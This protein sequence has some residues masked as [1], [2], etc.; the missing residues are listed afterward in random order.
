MVIN[1]VRDKTGCAVW[2]TTQSSD[3]YKY[4]NEYLKSCPPPPFAESFSWTLLPCFSF[5]G[6]TL[7]TW[8]FH[9]KGFMC[10]S[11]CFLWMK[12]CVTWV[13]TLV[14][15]TV[16]YSVLKTHIR[17]KKILYICQRLVFGAH[18]VKNNC[19]TSVLWRDY[20]CRKLSKSLTPL[21]ALLAQNKRDCWFQ[22]LGMTA[23]IVK[24]TA[25][26]LQDF[27]SDCIVRCE[28]WPLWSQARKTRD[29][30]MW[31]FLQQ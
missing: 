25:P 9:K 3:R 31:R 16:E 22:Q 15:K 30:C 21:I 20:Y 10:W 12:H 28:L 18:R 27:F 29:F 2:D 1:T 17:C 24:T 5:I 13:D 8:Y 4:Q 14:V 23:H 19:G 7:T 6:Y 26:F 11:V